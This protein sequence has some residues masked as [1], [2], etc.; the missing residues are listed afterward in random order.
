MTEV[1]HK[2]LFINGPPGSGKDT[3]GA[4][5]CAR[6]GWRKIQMKDPLW[7]GIQGFFDIPDNAFRKLF[8]DPEL[9]DKPSKFLCD[10]S[11]RRALISLS[12]DWAKE[13]Y[14][15]EVLGHLALRQ[16]SKATLVGGTVITD[17]GF[18][19]EARPII[20]YY[21][22][23]NCALMQLHREGCG[24]ANDSRSYIDLSQYGVLRSVKVINCYDKEFF[25]AQVCR[26]VQKWMDEDTR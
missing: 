8:T 7:R 16:M 3:A 2:V 12:E 5:I 15:D 19:Y 21:K 1:P 18:D 17:S 10:D 26:L 11:P 9:K 22:P 14:G 20:E 4:A 6:F 23:E 13:R 25:G 24:F